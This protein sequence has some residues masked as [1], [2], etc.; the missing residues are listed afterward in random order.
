[1]LLRT[2][3]VSSFLLLLACAA[4]VPETESRASCHGLCI[5]QR[6]GPKLSNG[7]SIVHNTPTA[8]RWSEFHAPR[9]GTVVNVATEEDVLTTVRAYSLYPFSPSCLAALMLVTAKGP[10]LQSIWAFLSCPEW[11]KRLGNHLRNRLERCGDKFERHQANHFQ[12]GKGS[13]H[14]ARWRNRL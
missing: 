9:P 8:P 7:A 11:G 5:N 4:A 12:S 3:L 1:M 13:S 2:F 14:I 6:L 10:V